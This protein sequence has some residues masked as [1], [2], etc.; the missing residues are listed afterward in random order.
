MNIALIKNKIVENIAIFNTLQD[1]INMLPLLDMD[2]AVE[3]IGGCNIG[4]TYENGVFISPVTPPSEMELKVQELEAKVMAL[5][6]QNEFLEECLIE[7]AA[8]V[9]A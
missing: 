5:T 6:N 7:M 8:I 9:Y 1:A 4:Y 2:D 3:A